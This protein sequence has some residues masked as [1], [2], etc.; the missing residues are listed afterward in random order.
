MNRELSDYYFTK[1]LAAARD[2]DLTKSISYSAISLGSNNAND[3]CRKLAGLC[4][5]QLGNYIMTEY[6]FNHSEYYARNLKDRI[7]E[8]SN[9]MNEAGQLARNRKYKKA[10]RLLENESDK[11]VNEY[12]YLGCLYVILHKKDKAAFCFLEALKI[13][14]SHPDTLLYL[15]NIQKSSGKRWWKKI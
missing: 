12:N 5:Y 6:I 8:K 3:N 11:S 7:L 13:D 9:K 15:K 2:D 14:S 10:I 4:Y 1:A